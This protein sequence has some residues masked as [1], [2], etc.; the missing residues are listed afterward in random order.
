M[1]K[2]LFGLC[3]LITVGGVITSCKDLTDDDD[4]SSSGSCGYSSTT[5]YRYHLYYTY[6]GY[7]YEYSSESACKSAASEK[8]YKYYC[9]DGQCYGYNYK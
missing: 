4:D 1:K 5:G 6:N 8:G 9:Y 2:L 7:S 3:V